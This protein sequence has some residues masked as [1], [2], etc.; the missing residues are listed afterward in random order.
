[1]LKQL[2]QVSLLGLALTGCTFHR[3]KSNAVYRD[4]DISTLTVGKS[5][6]R[7]VLN[8]LGPPSG[9]TTE[10]VS[11]G[12]NSMATFRYACA[13]ERQFTMLLAYLLYLPFKWGDKQTGHELIVEFTPQG[14]ISDLYAVDDSSVWRPFQSPVDRQVT[15][16]RDGVTP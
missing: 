7:D 8:E 9:S 6:W 1:M 4:L 15:F 13:D 3:T 5:T 10:K 12:L 11:A 14:V 16:Y 2:L